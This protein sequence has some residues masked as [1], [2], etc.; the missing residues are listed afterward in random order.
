M[1]ISSPTKRRLFQQYQ[2]EN[3]YHSFTH[4]MEAKGSIEITSLSPYVYKYDYYYYY[5]FIY[6]R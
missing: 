2:G 4:K 6:L 3:I 5:Y 1:I